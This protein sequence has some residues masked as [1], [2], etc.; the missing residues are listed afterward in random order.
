MMMLLLTADLSYW[1]DATATNVR[2]SPSTNES[3]S[4]GRVS[5]V[6]VKSNVNATRNDGNGAD[7]R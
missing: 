4:V 1:S 5:L 6:V 7:S 2:M 3:R